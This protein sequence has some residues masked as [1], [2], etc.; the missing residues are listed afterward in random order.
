MN[1]C[2]TNFTTNR[3]SQTIAAALA[4]VRKV[5]I[6]AAPLEI[7]LT[8][9]A[10]DEEEEPQEINAME[11]AARFRIGRPVTIGLDGSGSDQDAIGAGEP[12]DAPRPHESINLSALSDGDEDEG[13]VY[14]G[15]Q[16]PTLVTCAEC[17]ARLFAFSAGAHRAFHEQSGGST[18]KTV[19]TAHNDMKRPIG[20]DKEV[21]R[22]RSSSKPNDKRASD[23]GAKRRKAGL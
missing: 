22:S 19:A 12:R 2:A 11:P 9:L 13:I 5:P 8:G 16:R 7:D 1:I 3:P 23:G 21:K 10:S 15:E 14:V 20:K 18:R 6:K 17:G 4:G